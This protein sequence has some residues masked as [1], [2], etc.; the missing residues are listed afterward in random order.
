MI[1]TMRRPTFWLA[2]SARIQS[3]VMAFSLV[4]TLAMSGRIEQ[5]PS[6]VWEK[7]IAAKGGRERLHTV[8]NVHTVCSASQSFPKRG[9]KG[10]G[11]RREYLFA[12]PDKGWSWDDNRP[13]PFGLEVR[14]TNLERKVRW[15][16]NDADPKHTIQ[17]ATADIDENAFIQFQ[18]SNLLETQWLTPTPVTLS[19][20]IVR[21]RKVDIIEARWGSYRAE[22]Y[23]DES[24]HLPLKVTIYRFSPDGTQRLLSSG[25]LGRYADVDGIQMSG[26]VGVYGSDSLVEQIA[27]QTEINVDYD[28]AIF[29]HPPRIEDGPD[30]WRPKH[31][32]HSDAGKRKP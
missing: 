1:I 24:T 21:G 9:Y 31:A 3:S 19:Q 16:V 28:P 29:E 23:L 11:T 22:Y 7:A 17:F 12:L 13:S 27:C 5:T 20:G 2:A 14:V 25:P 4:T 10:L 15:V 32:N 6:E 30:A 26:G 8:R 18:L